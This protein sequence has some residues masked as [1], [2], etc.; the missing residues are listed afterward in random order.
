MHQ[1]KASS[2]FVLIFTCSSSRKSL[3]AYVGFLSCSDRISFF[4]ARRPYLASRRLRRTATSPKIRTSQGCVVIGVQRGGGV[5]LPPWVFVKDLTNKQTFLHIC[6]SLDKNKYIY[7]PHWVSPHPALLS[8]YAPVCGDPDITLLIFIFISIARPAVSMQAI[9][10]WPTIILITMYL[11]ISQRREPISGHVC[12][13]SRFQEPPPGLKCSSI[14][15]RCGASIEQ[16]HHPSLCRSQSRSTCRS[17]DI[18]C[19]TTFISP[20]AALFPDN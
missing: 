9:E 12:V 6:P 3:N 11:S 13:A 17:S 1:I 15:L 14:E 18:P 10:R 16:T 7:A 4:I 2:F 5:P 20:P 19:S 8:L